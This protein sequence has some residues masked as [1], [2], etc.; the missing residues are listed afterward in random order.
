[1]REYPIRA[2]LRAT[3]FEVWNTGSGRRAATTESHERDVAEIP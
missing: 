1:M 3:H 2:S